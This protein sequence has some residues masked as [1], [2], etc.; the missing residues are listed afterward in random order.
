[1]SLRELISLFLALF[2]IVAILIGGAVL[3]RY[4]TIE[5]VLYFVLGMIAL[6]FIFNALNSWLNDD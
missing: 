5:V 6:R 4:S 1:M 2:P 3:W